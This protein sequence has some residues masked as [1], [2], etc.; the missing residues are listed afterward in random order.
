MKAVQYSKEQ[1]QK[2]IKYGLLTIIF[3]VVLRIVLFDGPIRAIVFALT[4]PGGWPDGYRPNIDG[5]VQMPALLIGA[6][7]VGYPIGYPFATMGLSLAIRFNLISR[8]AA[9]GMGF[10][11][12]L[13]ASAL[14]TV[15]FSLG[16]GPSGTSSSLVMYSGV[17][18][19]K[20][21]INSPLGWWL[22][23]VN[24][25]TFALICS[26]GTFVMHRVMTAP[27]QPINKV[28]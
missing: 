26:F 22:E 9:I 24:T 4:Q 16:S 1:R 2:A 5:I 12:G 15:I 23:A 8:I 7:M 3:C 11:V 21:G 27:N 14:A 20:D 18:V 10:L 13:L 28:I 25:V 6:I 17:E 19:S